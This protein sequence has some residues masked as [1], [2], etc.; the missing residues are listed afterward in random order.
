MEPALAQSQSRRAH[1]AQESPHSSSRILA[2]V[3]RSIAALPL[4]LCLKSGR[5]EFPL[6]CSGPAL[7][8]NDQG[9][10]SPAGGR[11]ECHDS[12]PLSAEA[13]DLE[14][15]FDY[16][17]NTAPT[18]LYAG[19]GGGAE[20]FASRC[21]ARRWRCT[22]RPQ[23]LTKEKFNAPPMAEPARGIN[24]P[25]HFSAVSRRCAGQVFRE[26]VFRPNPYRNRCR[27]LLRPPSTFQFS[28]R[29]RGLQ[30]RRAARGVG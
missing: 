3:L 27:T 25:T 5:R 17:M 16:W 22:R 4:Y 14:R 8:K 15:L 29:G 28:G 1:G 19:A 26:F 21:F 11:Q 12:N 13:D 20:T 7:K 10:S 2:S 30:I 9:N 18:G 24:R 23:P 6:R